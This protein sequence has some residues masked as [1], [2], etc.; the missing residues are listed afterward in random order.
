MKFAVLGANSFTGSNLCA[1]LREQG[2]EV[3]E[4]SRPAFDLI[5]DLDDIVRIIRTAKP[6]Y[7][8][9]FIAKGRVPESWNK[10]ADWM[11]TNVVAHVALHDQLRHCDFIEKYVHVSTPEVYG[12]TGSWVKEDHPFNPSTPYAVSKAACEMSLRTFRVYGFPVVFTRA[13]NVYGPGQTNRLIPNAIAAKRDGRKLKLEGD[14]LRCFVHVLDVA[15]ATRL[16]ALK[17]Q[18]G[19]AYHISTRHMTTIKQVVEMVGCD[20]ESVTPRMAQDS[21]Y[22]LRTDKLRRLGWT[23]TVTLEQGINEMEAHGH[24]N[25]LVAVA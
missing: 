11:H 17:G 1:Y 22:A 6:K 19:E 21:I 16:V 15:T 13:A 8:V 7:I 25:R 10:P 20:Y 14:C 5:R 9:N 18:V 4:I 2:D 12:S 3:L 23:D 24:R